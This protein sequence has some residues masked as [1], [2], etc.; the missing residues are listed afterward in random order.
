MIGFDGISTIVGY[1]MSNPLYMFA[2]STGAVENANCI[3]PESVLYMTLN[4][5][6][7]RLQ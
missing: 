3:S 2:Q 7:V 1:L 4:N 5:L 6:M